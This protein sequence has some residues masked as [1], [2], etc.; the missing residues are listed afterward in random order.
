MSVVYYANTLL[1]YPPWAAG[2][3]TLLTIGLWNAA[4]PAAEKGFGA[5][6]FVL[7][8]FAAVAVQKNVRD[9]GTPSEERSS[10]Q[11]GADR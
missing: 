8:L 11:M 5:M 9:I 6:S 7:S 4:L 3:V 2:G 1:A 10:A